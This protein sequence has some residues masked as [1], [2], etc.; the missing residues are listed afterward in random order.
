MKGLDLITPDL[1]ISDPIMI[2]GSEIFSAPE[3]LMFSH[4]L[5]TGLLRQISIWNTRNYQGSDC[6]RTEG[7]PAW[8]DR[9]W[10]ERAGIIRRTA[11]D[12]D[13]EKFLL[14]ALITYE[15]GKN[16]FEAIAESG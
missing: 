12:P 13:S 7:F 4:R 8:R 5:T 15:C 3:F 16:R 1:G 2:G 11:E 6:H 9:E 14:A 10:E